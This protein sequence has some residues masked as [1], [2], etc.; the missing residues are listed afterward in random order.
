MAV[1]SYAEGFWIVG[2][3]CCFS[4]VLS[5]FKPLNLTSDIAQGLCVLLN[6]STIL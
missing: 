3:C 2:I 5:A 1:T 4:I 6:A